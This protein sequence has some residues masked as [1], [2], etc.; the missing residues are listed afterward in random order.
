MN[1]S[2]PCDATYKRFVRDKCFEALVSVGFTRFRKEGVDWPFQNGFHCWVG[3]NTALTSGYVEIN[4]FVGLHVVPIMKLYTGLEGRKYDRSIATVA[5]HMGELAPDEQ[6]FRFSRNSDVIAEAARLAKLYID[7]GLTFALSIATFERLLPLLQDQVESLR[8][9]PE[10]TAICLNLM[11]RKDEARVFTKNFLR[12][13]RSYFERF[14][15]PFL[16]M[17]NCPN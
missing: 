11:G 6:A 3:L 7:V 17:L 14:A 5:R 13:H 1:S 8:S 2:K 9:Y 4:P 15:I 10:R 12:D 16:E